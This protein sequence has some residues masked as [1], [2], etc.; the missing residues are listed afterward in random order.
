METGGASC[1]INNHWLR[2]VLL[3]SRRLCASWGECLGN[4]LSSSVDSREHQA[5]LLKLRNIW[6]EDLLGLFQIGVS[7]ALLEP[8]LGEDG[9]FLSCIMCC[10]RLAELTLEQTERPLS[11]QASAFLP[12]G[13]PSPCCCLPIQ[14]P[15]LALG[16]FCGAFLPTVPIKADP[17]YLA[18]PQDLGQNRTLSSCVSSHYIFL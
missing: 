14:V 7:Q 12:T 9:L 10:L 17:L 2:A 1:R 15:S 3:E 16:L 13:V 18:F 6:L 4:G 5:E 8:R 11:W